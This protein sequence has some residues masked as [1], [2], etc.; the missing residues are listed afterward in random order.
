MIVLCYTFSK[1]KYGLKPGDGEERK[2]LYGKVLD[3]ISQC[4]L[5]KIP[6]KKPSA[7]DCVDWFE[8]TAIPTRTR[9][10]VF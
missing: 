1:F 5:V 3:S 4:R 7:V 8:I 2:E 10:G 9:Y 6:L